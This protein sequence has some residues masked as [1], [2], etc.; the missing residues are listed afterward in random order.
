LILDISLVY[1]DFAQNNNELFMLMFN[2]ERPIPNE[3][4]ESIFHHLKG[5]FKILA[6]GDE[7]VSQEL[8]LAWACLLHGALFVLFIIKPPHFEYRDKREVFT[9]IINR[10]LN[11]L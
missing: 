6:Q 4:M 9:A 8:M 3:E 11:S 1:W 10:F 2:I 7:D 5:V